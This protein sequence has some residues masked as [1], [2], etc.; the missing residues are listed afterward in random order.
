M[1]ERQQTS[2]LSRPIQLTKF[3]GRHPPVL[4]TL[5]DA[6]FFLSATYSST[7]IDDR[8]QMLSRRIRTAEHTHD[9]AVIDDVT[10]QLESFLSDRGLL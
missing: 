7:V 6:A 9:A 4:S 3:N 5:A 2:P 10:R 1:L 8:A